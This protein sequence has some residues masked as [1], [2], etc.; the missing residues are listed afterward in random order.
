MILLLPMLLHCINVSGQRDE[1]IQTYVFEV[2]QPA[3]TRSNSSGPVLMIAN[4]RA[5]TGVGTNAIIY[6]ERSY[7]IRQYSRSQWAERPDRMLRS[8]LLN[9]FERSGEF[10]AIVGIGYGSMADLRLDTDLIQLQHEHFEEPS[11]AR[12]RIRAQLIDLESQEIVA[13][14]T[15]EEVE[16]AQSDDPYGGV[17]AIN[18]A[19]SRMIDDIVAFTVETTRNRPVSD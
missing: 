1:P 12:V 4:V 19:L 18:A 11:Q 9:A 13:T 14:R 5:E 16:S 3:T 7:E 2:D 6:V 10:G 8:L 15:F 17:V